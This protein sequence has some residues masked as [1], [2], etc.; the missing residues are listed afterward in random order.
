MKN[1]D[2]RI[3][4]KAVG[5]EKIIANHLPDERL[6]SRIYKEL[7]KINNKKTINPTLK[8]GT[9]FYQTLPKK[10]CRRQIKSKRH[11]T[12]LVTR[13]MPTKKTMKYL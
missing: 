1:T 2:E 4:R 9:I 6:V 5:K 11:L 12:S 3:V 8:M 10:I 13:K 7:S